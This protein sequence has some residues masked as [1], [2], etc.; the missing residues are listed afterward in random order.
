MIV[1]F[2][3]LDF[4]YQC[5]A[6]GYYNTAGTDRSHLWPKRRPTKTAVCMTKRIPWKLP[7]S[8]IGWKHEKGLNSNGENLHASLTLWG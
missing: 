3:H 2:R 6:I 1:N 4:D 8:S 5:G 7:G